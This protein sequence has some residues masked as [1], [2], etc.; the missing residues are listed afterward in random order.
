MHPRSPTHAT[1]GASSRQAVL[2]KQRYFLLA[3]LG[4]LFSLSACAQPAPPAKSAA[5]KPAAPAVAAGSPEERVRNAIHKLN[6]QVEIDHISAA[7]IAGFREAIVGGQTLYVSDDGRYLLQGN[8]YDMNAKE[9]LSQRNLAKVRRQLLDTIPVADR[10]VFAPPSPKYTV[11]VFTDVECGY[12]RKLHS[13]IAEYNRQG[14]AVQ[15]LA[16]PRMGLGSPDFQKM[17]N[18]WCA[19][20]RKKALTDAKNDQA[21]PVKNCKNPVTMEYDIGQRVGLQGTPMII[22]DKGEVMPGYMPPDALRATLD[23]LAKGASL[24]DAL[25]SSMPAAAA[26]SP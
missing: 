1:I 20:D 21:V 9:N 15:Y 11:S 6:S 4:S 7:P 13:Q 17:V 5:D 14:I 10:I 23:K 3:L 22:T 24:N 16:F 8:L 26:G 18:V 19:A 2:M 12:C 25:A